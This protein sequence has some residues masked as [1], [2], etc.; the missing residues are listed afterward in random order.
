LDIY[1]GFVY[2]FRGSFR[3]E[4]E[5]VAHCVKVVL[6]ISFLLCDMSY[7][8]PSSSCSPVGRLAPLMIIQSLIMALRQLVPSIKLPESVI[9]DQLQSSHIERRLTTYHPSVERI[10]RSYLLRTFLLILQ[11]QSSVPV[12]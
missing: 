6:I 7:H 10:K 12:G 1:D 2:R 8:V 4:S 11:I 3:V 5:V 9:Y